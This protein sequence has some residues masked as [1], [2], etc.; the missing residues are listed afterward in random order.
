MPLDAEVADILKASHPFELIVVDDGS[1]DGTADAIRRVMAT[2]SW[3]RAF[4]HDRSCG[5]S[6]A[7]RTAILNAYA[8]VIVTID[9]DGQND[10]ADIPRLI[11]LLELREISSTLAMVAGERKQRQDSAIKKVS[12]RIANTVRRSLLSDGSHDIGCGLKAFD[13]DAYYSISTTSTGSIRH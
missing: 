10:P 1:D 9:G 12:S 6:A 4:K 3:I 5:Q 2:H 11:K 8:P 13:R 7:Q